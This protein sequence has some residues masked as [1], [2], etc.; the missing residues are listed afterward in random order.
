MASKTKTLKQSQS[1][2]FTWWMAIILVAVIAVI[3]LA[4]IRLSHASSKPGYTAASFGCPESAYGIPLQ[5][6][7]QGSTGGCVTY[8]QR[9]IDDYYVAS[10][11]KTKPPINPI[12]GVFGSSTTA[13]VKNFQG[14]QGL[15]QDGIVNTKTWGALV[16][17][18]YVS[19]QCNSL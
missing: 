16:K 8:L 13:F 10:G 15:T 9:M 6:L 14:R 19:L 12:D 3:G 1:F 2:K 7:Q 11:I 5:T 17:A 18:C 4:I